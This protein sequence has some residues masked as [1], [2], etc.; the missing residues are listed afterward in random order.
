[1]N[2]LDL[3]NELGDLLMDRSDVEPERLQRYINLAYTDMVTSLKIAEMRASISLV[4]VAD[5]P[6]YLLPGAVFAIEGAAI[7]EEGEAFLESG[8]PL[9][10]SDLSSYRGR[11]LRSAPVT[12]FFR[13]GDMLV[14]WPTPEGVAT[15]ALDFW[16]R[17]D[18]LE[19]PADCP[20]LGLE[21]HEGILLSA[22]H[23]MLAA[24]QEWEASMIAQN[25]YVSF[26]RKRMDVRAVEDEGKVMRSSVPGRN[27]M[28]MRRRRPWR[29][30]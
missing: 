29:D 12:E 3:E 17:P 23:K 10:V 13:H 4:T 8:R 26:V 16:V 5:Q 24:L 19:D 11:P 15:V 9:A 7:I 28:V 18:W 21:W 1:M 14:L 27:R 30:D 22:R 25:E 20:I 2:F 6:F